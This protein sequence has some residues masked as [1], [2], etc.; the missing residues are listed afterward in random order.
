MGS[1]VAYMVA[2][3]SEP[4]EVVA[5][6]DVL[7]RGGVDVVTV[8]VTGSIDVL[9][10]QDL[11]LTADALVQD[12]N[13]FDGFDMVVVPGGSEGVKAMAA[14]EALTKDLTARMREDRLVAAICAAPT[15]LADL[16]LLEGRR[17]VCYPGCQDGFP[18]G[19]YQAGISVC[20]DGSLITATGPGTALPFG[21]MLLHIL[22]GEKKAEEVAAS[23]LL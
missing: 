15:I 2:D 1:T 4:L 3:G 8:S 7:R 12:V 9:L 11:R 23:M 16:G 14:C 21:K 17:A 19:A 13:L 22:E 6:V 10:A 5:P 18:D 20:V